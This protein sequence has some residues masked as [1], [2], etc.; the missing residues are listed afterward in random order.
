[1]F[2]VERSRRTERT[3]EYTIAIIVSL[4]FLYVFNNLLNWHIYFVTNALNEVLWII[5]LSLLATIIGNALFILYRADWFRHLVKIV[6]NIFNII[7][8][9]LVY[10]VFPFNF[11][12]SFLNW[13]IN[14]LLILIMIRIVIAIIVEFYHLITGKTN[15]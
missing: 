9:Y 15:Y 8:V 4:I 14:I 6:I 11:N 2:F 1:M 5:N 12:N 13:A 10:L 3:T 7:A